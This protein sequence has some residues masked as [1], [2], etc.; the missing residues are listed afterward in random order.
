M[1]RAAHVVKN[2]KFTVAGE[3]MLA[4]LKF[5]SR[6]AFVLL[7]G[8][9]Y[10]GLNGLFTDILSVL[11]LAELGLGVSITYSLYRPAARGDEELI[12]SLIRLCRRAYQCVGLA[13]LLA[14]LSLTPFLSFF[15]KEMPENIPHIPLIY[16][17]NVVNVSVS[18]LFSYRATLLFVYQKKYIESVIRALTGLLFTVAQIGVLFLTGNYLYYL[19][20]ATPPR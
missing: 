18:Y 15:V 16:I 5:V 10:L 6:R 3:L 1:D 4:V 11:A 12:R 20:L 8:K 2:F 14:G 7:L 9:E 17:L 13:I 19:Y